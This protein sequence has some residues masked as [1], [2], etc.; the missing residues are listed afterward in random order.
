[1]S[2]I[3]CHSNPEGLYIWHDTSNRIA[4][5]SKEHDKI[6]WAP[7]SEFNR[8]IRKERAFH[9]LPFKTKNLWLSEVTV[10]EGTNTQIKQRENV[11]F[12]N[13]IKRTPPDYKIKLSIRG[14]GSIYMWRVTWSYICGTRAV[15]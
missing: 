13:W 11:S 8:L 9:P 15:K 5:V 6:L 12:E 2:Y 1:M 14:Q 10:T 4:I 3:R 7:V